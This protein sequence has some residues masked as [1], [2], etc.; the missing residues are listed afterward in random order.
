MSTL[1]LILTSLEPLPWEHS[2]ARGNEGGAALVAAPSRR[3]P[4]TVAT[5]YAGGLL[6]SVVRLKRHRAS[7]PKEDPRID[8]S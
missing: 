2:R 3:A 6:H 4:R 8:P 5:V 1:P 7:V